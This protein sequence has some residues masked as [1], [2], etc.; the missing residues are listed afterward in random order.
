VGT[1]FFIKKQTRMTA[2]IE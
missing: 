2:F 1:F